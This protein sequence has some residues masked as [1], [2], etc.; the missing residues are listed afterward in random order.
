MQHLW[1]RFEV[2][3]RSDDVLGFG[4]QD[5]I[6]PV[7]LVLLISKQFYNIRYLGCNVKPNPSFLRVSLC[8][9]YPH[10]CVCT[11]LI[12]QWTLWVRKMGI[13]ILKTNTSFNLSDKPPIK[14][15]VSVSPVTAIPTNPK[16][17]LLHS[18]Y[19]KKPA[20]QLLD[21]H[22]FSYKPRQSGPD[23][24]DIVQ[25]QCQIDVSVAQW[26]EQIAVAVEMLKLL[27]A[28]LLSFQTTVQQPLQFKQI[29][30][31]PHR[32]SI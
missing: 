18:V 24:Q 12:Y 31:K 13:L 25:Q 11:L 32:K 28:F 15:P 17:Y 29:L 1:S 21:P 10:C 6:C 9:I 7:N 2:D 20:I 14:P 16:V 8:A 19:Q 4:F 26:T 5:E 22:A 30:I 3:S 23:P 27:A